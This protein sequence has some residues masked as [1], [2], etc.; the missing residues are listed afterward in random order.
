MSDIIVLATHTDNAEV[1]GIEYVSLELA[2][3]Q[4]ADGLVYLYA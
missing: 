4:T 2:A 3:M 1:M